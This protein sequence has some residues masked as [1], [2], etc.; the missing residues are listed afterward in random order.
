MKKSVLLVIKFV[1][2]LVKSV[3]L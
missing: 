1:M 2:L 3:V